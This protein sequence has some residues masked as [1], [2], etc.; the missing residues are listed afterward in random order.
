MPINP[1]RINPSHR[2]S[3]IHSHLRAYV[4][5]WLRL[6]PLIAL[7]TIKTHG[8]RI[9]LQI[10]LVL[11]VL[12]LWYIEIIFKVARRIYKANWFMGTGHIRS[13]VIYSS[14]SRYRRKSILLLDWRCFCFLELYWLT[15]SSVWV[16]LDPIL[17]KIYWY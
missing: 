2:A 17:I 10:Y 7:K 3:A 4:G 15:L 5:V 9:V 1:C 14:S 12:F 6:D 8:G 11:I 13:Y 16:C